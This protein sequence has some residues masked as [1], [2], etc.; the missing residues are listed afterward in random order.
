MSKNGFTVLQTGSSVGGNCFETPPPRAARDQDTEQRPLKSKCKPLKSSLQQRGTWEE[1]LIERGAFSNS[2]PGLPDSSFWEL[3][4][5]SSVLFFLNSDLF[6]AHQN[7]SPRA[8]SLCSYSL[9]ITKIRWYLQKNVNIT[10]TA[11]KQGE[12][13]LKIQIAANTQVSNMEVSRATMTIPF[14]G[15]LPSWHLLASNPLHPPVNTAS[16]SSENWGKKQFP[17]LCP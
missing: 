13:L 5:G 3:S 10:K 14:P 1:P 9:K 4:P 12:S 11:E 2:S 8:K 6:G 15:V 17:V 7:S 16:T